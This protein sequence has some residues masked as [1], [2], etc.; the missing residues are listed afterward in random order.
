MANVLSDLEA[1]EQNLT[2]KRE[3]ARNALIANVETMKG[4]Y[5]AALEELGRHFP[6]ERAKLEGGKVKKSKGQSTAIGITDSEINT[7]IELRGQGLS[8]DDVKTHLKG[9]RQKTI[10]KLEEAYKK[11][12]TPSAMRAFID[13][14]AI[15]EAPKAEAKPILKKKGK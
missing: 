14:K 11:G 13:G 10:D 9:R 2:E 5:L 8:L 15:E 6:E 3:A 4:N 12:K 7:F 1:A